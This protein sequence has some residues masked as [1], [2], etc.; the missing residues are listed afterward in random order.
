M[1]LTESRLKEIED[2][3]A[4]TTPG[5]WAHEWSGNEGDL[6]AGHGVVAMGHGEICRIRG[7]LPTAEQAANGVFIAEAPNDVA[8]LLAEVR[9]LRQRLREQGLAE[10]E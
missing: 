7:H 10:T 3:L 9:R 4:K 8:E 2:R 5:P 1:Q 6:E